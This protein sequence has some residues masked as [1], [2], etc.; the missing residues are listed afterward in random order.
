MNETLKELAIRIIE[1]KRKFENPY[2]PF[3]ENSTKGGFYE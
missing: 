2:L 1:L 3:N